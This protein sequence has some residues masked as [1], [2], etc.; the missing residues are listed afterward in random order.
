MHPELE[1]TLRTTIESYNALRENKQLTNENVE[2]HKSACID[3]L[4]DRVSRLDKKDDE[5]KECAFV[6]SA[7]QNGWLVSDIDMLRSYYQAVQ[8]APNDKYKMEAESLLYI[9]SSINIEK[10]VDRI[11]MLQ[12]VNQNMY[13]LKFGNKEL[14]KTFN[15]VTDTYN[16]KL[17]YPPEY[18]NDKDFTRISGNED[19][20]VGTSYQKI[21]A[22]RFMTLSAQR[23][24]TNQV[25]YLPEVDDPLAAENAENFVIGKWHR[26][27]GGI[28][29]KTSLCVKEALGTEVYDEIYEM[30][31]GSASDRKVKLHHSLG[32]KYQSQGHDVLEFEFAGSGGQDAYRPHKGR[33]GIISLDNKSAETIKEEYGEKAKVPHTKNKYFN[34]LWK[35]ERTLHLPDDSTAQKVRYTI[36]GPSPTTLYGLPNFGDYSIQSSRDNATFYAGEFLKERFERWARGE[37]EPKPIHIELSGHSRGA[38]TAGQTVIKI[39]D[40]IQKYCRK[41]PDA[42]SRIDF[43]KFVHYDLILRDPVPGFGTNRTIGDCDLRNIPNVNATV[44]CSLGIQAPD[45]LFP[46]QHIRGAKK[47]ILNTMDHQVDL[48]TSDMSQVNYAGAAK[49]GSMMSY[50]DPE[51]GEV[52]RGS[53]LSE[54]PDGVYIADEKCRLIRVTSYSQMKEFY[55]STFSKSTPQAIRSRRI[56]KMV[57]DWFCENELQMSF[58]DEKTRKAETA[59]A[60]GIKDK[61]LGMNVQRL[62]GVQE[63]LRMIDE[64]KADPNTSKEQLLRA[65][66]DLIQACRTYMKKTAMPPEGISADKAGMVGD[67][68]SFTMRE[69]NQLSKELNLVSANDP[70]AVLDEKIRAQKNKLEQREGY[71]QRKQAAEQERLTKEQDIQKIIN[72][73]KRSCDMVTEALKRTDKWKKQ[74]TKFKSI[75]EEGSKFGEKTSMREI[76][77]FLKRYSAQ[78]KAEDYYSL[79]AAAHKAGE[80]L[81]SYGMADQDIPIGIRLQNRQASI[82]FLQSKQLELQQA[83]NQAQAP[84]NQHALQNQEEN[85]HNQVQQEQ[86][87][88]QPVLNL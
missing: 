47:L 66:K 74:N 40:W 60:A 31:R 81:K 30:S 51:T 33:R 75:L 56:H 42:A 76:K 50:F 62:R 15:L 5:F 24:R 7:L 13:N 22:E 57:R 38:V 72:E 6:L 58:P 54:L 26:K 10:L 37:E 46:L 23:S 20:T 71:L 68:L 79:S 41:N 77:D 61:L 63:K 27:I 64:L 52:H 49:T 11:E 3:A 53:G 4:A 36:A 45:D 67:I 65:N 25:Y 39:N 43:R 88:P 84:Q 59:K 28:T 12:R 78:A 18:P 17:V 55:N 8:N 69:N 86:Q 80:K 32:T 87:E 29:R 35:K 73:T 44:F 1:Q 16:K 9:I 70:R 19:P 34:F 21:G 2:Q 14:Q 82:D 48:M 83:R 85:Q